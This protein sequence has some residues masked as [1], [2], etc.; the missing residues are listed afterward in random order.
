MLGLHPPS[1]NPVHNSS[2]SY[3]FYS[4]TTGRRL[5][6]GQWTINTMHPH[7]I[8]RIN[9][10]GS[11]QNEACI[12][13]GVDFSNPYDDEPKHLLPDAADDSDDSTCN[14]ESDHDDDDPIA[15]DNSTQLQQNEGTH[16]DIIT[17]EEDIS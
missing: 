10:A 15:N 7:V 1:L 14:Y 13:L 9:D 16:E 6:R 17:N 11:P 2:G 8:N 4:I 5:T 12:H 3:Y